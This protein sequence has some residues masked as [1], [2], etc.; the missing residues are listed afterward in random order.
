MRV[1]VARTLARAIAAGIDARHIKNPRPA[2][3]RLSSMG[4]TY[5]PSKVL[6]LNGKPYSLAGA[7]QYIAAIEKRKYSMDN[8]TG[9]D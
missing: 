2:T 3:R 7:R 8:Q 6:M 1:V 4:S 9:Q 5:S